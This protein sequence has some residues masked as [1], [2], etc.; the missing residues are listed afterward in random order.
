MLS[1]GL[2]VKCWNSPDQML[3]LR[4][5]TIEVSKNNYMHITASTCVYIYIGA[6]NITILFYNYFLWCFTMKKTC[7]LSTTGEN[8]Q[9]TGQSGGDRMSLLSRHLATPAQASNFLW[10]FLGLPSVWEGGVDNE[11]HLW[12]SWVPEAPLLCAFEEAIHVLP[13]G[14][15]L[16]PAPLL[17]I[18]SWGR[19]W[20]AKR[21]KY[22]NILF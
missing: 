17:P 18:S 15:P 5:D 6:K 12:G 3:Y 14:L 2:Y 10:F 11:P 22:I 9:T 4:T 1:L 7:T 13:G 16:R 21:R 20:D 8:S 19:R